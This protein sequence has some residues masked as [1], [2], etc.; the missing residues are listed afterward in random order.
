MKYENL[1]VE[2][3]NVE[4]NHFNLINDLQVSLEKCLKALPESPLSLPV[5]TKII[6]K[7]KNII[8]DHLSFSPYD[9]TDKLYEIVMNYFLNIG[10]EIYFQDSFFIIERQIIDINSELVQVEN[11][12]K[13]SSKFLSTG[14]GHGDQ[15]ILKGEWVLKS[16]APRTCMTYKFQEIHFK[17]AQK[18]FSCQSCNLNCI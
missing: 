14:L 3:T 1:E 7:R 2:K 11:P 5:K 6:L 8:I 16:E 15:I 18:Y 10:D 13:K 9:D 12:I 4:R 17:T